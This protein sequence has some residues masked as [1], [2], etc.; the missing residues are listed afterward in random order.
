MGQFMGYASYDLITICG[1][2]G[3]EGP[4]EDMKDHYLYCTE[5]DK[6]DETEEEEEDEDKQ[7]TLPEAHEAWERF[8]ANTRIIGFE[9]DEAGEK[10][11]IRTNVQRIMPP[12]TEGLISR[13]THE[14][15]KQT[16][17]SRN[18]SSFSQMGRGERL[19][20]GGHIG[21]FVRSLG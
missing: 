7:L 11:A 2:C 18:E 16:M 9:V 5:R 14:P 6:D 10:R 20:T 13:T 17:H 3:E 15:S 21:L 4:R 1:H 8:W 12:T 19:G